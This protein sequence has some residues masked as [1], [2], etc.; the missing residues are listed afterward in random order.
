M[1]EQKTRQNLTY[2]KCTMFR[3][4]KKIVSKQTRNRMFATFIFL[5]FIDFAF[6]F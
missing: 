3:K 6:E 5:S 2:A 4:R 1:C